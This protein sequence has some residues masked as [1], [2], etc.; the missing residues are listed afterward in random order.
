MASLNVGCGKVILDG[1]IN[2]DV[3]GGDVRC[4]A[5]ALPFRDGSFNRILASHVLEHIPDLRGVMLEFHRVLNPAGGDVLVRVPYG[6]RKLCEAFHYRAFDLGT[7]DHFCHEDPNSLEYER[8]F[9]I[10]SKEISGYEFPKFV[11]TML[12]SRWRAGVR[13]WL[14]RLGCEDRE[15]DGRIINP[16]PLTRRNEITWILTRT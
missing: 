3:L 2:A 1:W 14:V 15:T 9:K 6:L 4:D 12:G 10:A 16:F 8:L 13:H 11:E 7:M 5:R